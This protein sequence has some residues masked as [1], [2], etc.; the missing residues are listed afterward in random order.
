VAEEDIKDKIKTSCINIIYVLYL[1][2][3]DILTLYRF[4]CKL[5]S[6]EL[7]IHTNNVFVYF[8]CIPTDH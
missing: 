2:I 6:T 1:C 3:I 8:H 4:R 7:H 5:K